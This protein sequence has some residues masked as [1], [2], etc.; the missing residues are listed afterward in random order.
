MSSR[1]FTAPR[2]K[3]PTGL[4]RKYPLDRASL[5]QDAAPA[6][7]EPLSRRGHI[8]LA[9][10]A[11]ELFAATTATLV[12]AGYRLAT[13]TDVGEALQVMARERFDLLVI[14]SARGSDSI[15]HLLRRVRAHEGI[16]RPATSPATVAI[17][18]VTDR[19]A[20]KARARRREALAAGA[21]D[22]LVAPFPPAELLLR[23]ATLLRR[24]ARTPPDPRETLTLAD[25]HIDVAAHQVLVRDRIVELTPAEF[26]MLRMLAERRGQLCTRASLAT[27]ERGTRRGVDMRV[28]RIRRKLG[29]AGLVI[30]C[31]RGHGYRLATAGARS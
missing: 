20:P 15:A 1:R 27:T 31:I 4:A 9:A 24:I 30:E 19:S 5:G 22:V 26:T 10:P 14:G 11:P 8:L 23:V 12:R 29:D 7:S 16:A 6:V 21:D 13:V 28:S 25:L 17:L 3:K 18:V 2:G